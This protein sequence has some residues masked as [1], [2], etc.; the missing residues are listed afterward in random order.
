VESGIYPVF[1]VFRDSGGADGEITYPEDFP[2]AYPPGVNKN[3]GRI[4]QGGVLLATTGHVHT[5][6]LSTNLY[7]RRNDAT[8]AGPNCPDRI[9]YDDQL[10]P[11]QTKHSNF[12]SRIK[13]I[14]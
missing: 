13:G 10:T 6:G 7:L 9:S 14:K 5:G 3:Q 4:G 8:Y 2:N 1:D 12:V 11:L